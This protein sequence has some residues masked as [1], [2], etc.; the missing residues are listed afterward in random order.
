LH[1]GQGFSADKE[2]FHSYRAPAWWLDSF[3]KAH[4]GKD[5]TWAAIATTSKLKIFFIL[6]ATLGIRYIGGED[7]LSFEAC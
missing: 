6:R 1:H 3:G 5:R 4:H 7:M 2:Q